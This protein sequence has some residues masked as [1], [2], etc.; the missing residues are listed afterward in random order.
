MLIYIVNKRKEKE[1]AQLNEIDISDYV[2]SMEKYTKTCYINYNYRTKALT[3]WMEKKEHL[4]LD[5]IDQWNYKARLSWVVSLNEIDYARF[6]IG[7]HLANRIPS[8]YNLTQLKNVIKMC[9]NLKISMKLGYLD[10]F[11]NLDEIIQEAYILDSIPELWR[12]LNWENNGTWSLVNNNY[13]NSFNVTTVTDIM[14]FKNKIMWIK[15]WEADEIDSTGGSEDEEDDDDDD[16]ESSKENDTS[17]QKS[18]SKNLKTSSPQRKAKSLLDPVPNPDLN[19]NLPN[20]LYKKW[21]GLKRASSA[22]PNRV[23]VREELDPNASKVVLSVYL[24]VASVKPY[25]SLINYK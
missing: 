23:I 14:S 7:Y 24:L 18:A 10:T 19:P 17:V 15:A 8:L 4:E 6:K 11:V 12:F 20:L 1:R 3:T 9:E 5:R 13:S 2:T 16:E 25:L 22:L 21:R